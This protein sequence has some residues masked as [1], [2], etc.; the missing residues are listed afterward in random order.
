MYVSFF[1]FKADQRHLED[2]NQTLAKGFG[3]YMMNIKLLEPE[4]VD[5]AFKAGEDECESFNKLCR[6]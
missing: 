5:F 4:F 2:I 6:S 3:F 1:T